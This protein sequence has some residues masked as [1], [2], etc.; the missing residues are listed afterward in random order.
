MSVPGMP[1]PSQPPGYPH[2]MQ[3]VQPAQPQ[4]PAKTASYMLVG[5]CVLLLIGTFS[6]SWFGASEG[7]VSA[8][9]GPMGAEACF[10]GSC[11]ESGFDGPD[12]VPLLQIVALLG[13]VASAA[14]AGMFGGM[15]LANKKDKIPPA[16]Q[17]RFVPIIFGIAAVGFVGFFLRVVSE[18]S[19]KGMGISW[20]WVPAF[21]GVVLAYLGFQRLLPFLPP[22]GAPRPIGFG[23]QP[24]QPGQQPYV[25]QPQQP[26][27]QQPQQPWGNQSQPMQPQQYGQQPM[28]Q[29]P[30]GQQ[31][32]QPQ[33]PYGQQPAAQQ[34]VAQQPVAMMAGPGAGA[35]PN[36]PR[37]GA[38]LQFVAQY[39]RWFCSRDNQYV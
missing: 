30:Y 28:Q 37:C 3:P 27:G 6:K 33:Q 10:H 36:C 16:V 4:D 26:Y 7:D 31:P 11:H 13:G 35:A 25:Q 2:Q 5:A 20:A 15:Y 21:A 18:G 1:P 17:Y 14:A 34:P 19:S 24:N 22:Q 12:V 8:H 39:Q 23:Q 9:F 32:M 29:Q 38:P